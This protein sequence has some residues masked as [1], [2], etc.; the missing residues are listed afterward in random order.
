MEKTENVNFFFF[1]AFLVPG[2]S[3]NIHRA[4]NWNDQVNF[5]FLNSVR[6]VSQSEILEKLYIHT[7]R[8]YLFF[9]FFIYLFFFFVIFYHKKGFI[10]YSGETL[11]TQ[12]KPLRTMQTYPLSC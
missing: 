3:V 5:L 9:L 8:S 10:F 2:C 4:L 1:F 7:K 12:L 6:S 11:S